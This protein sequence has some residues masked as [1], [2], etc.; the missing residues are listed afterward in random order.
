V[1]LLYFRSLRLC[2]FSSSDSVELDAET[3]LAY[4]LEVGQPLTTSSYL[5]TREACRGLAEVIL[6]VR[7][8]AD[9]WRHF[10]E[11]EAIES[12]RCVIPR[13]VAVRNDFKSTI[14]YAGPRS[15][16][17]RATAFVARH[18]LPPFVQLLTLNRRLIERRMSKI[19]IVPD[20]SPIALARRAIAR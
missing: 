3:Q 10:Y 5:I 12:L 2:S 7:V 15:M 1:I 17:M 20:P 16:R 18:R 13:P 9:N 8:A 4:P 19:R 14:E 6:P 11:L